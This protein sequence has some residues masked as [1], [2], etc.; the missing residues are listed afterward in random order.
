MKAKKSKLI[1]CCMCG[2]EI[3]IPTN[4]KPIT[5]HYCKTV[6]RLAENGY[7]VIEMYTKRGADY[8][9]YTDADVPEKVKKFMEKHK[10]IIINDEFSKYE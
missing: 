4:G 1:V 10:R 2:N 3:R 8:K 9:T 5:C 7:D 6:Q